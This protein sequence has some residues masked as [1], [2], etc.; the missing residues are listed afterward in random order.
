MKRPDQAGASK[1]LSELH[2][3]SG[4][5]GVQIDDAL[6]L[7][8]DENVVELL[9]ATHEAILAEGLIDLK[10][11]G[12][13]G[14]GVVLRATDSATGNPRAVKVMINADSPDRMVI[15]DRECRILDAAE[16]PP[17]VA[18][19]FY[20]AVKPQSAQ[21]FVVQ[22]WIS[23]QKLSDWLDARPKLPMSDRESLCRLIFATYSKLHQANLIHRD[24]SLGNIMVS[25]RTIRLIDF[26]GGGRAVAGYR[27]RNT[28]SQ[29][30][31]TDAFV[32]NAVRLRE[33]KPSI[34]DEVHA[35]AKVCFTVLTGQ[36]AL[37]KSPNDWKQILQL[38]RVAGDIAAIV[39][40][41]MQEPPQ[42][43]AMLSQAREF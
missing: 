34:A 10:R 30:P 32:S 43:L 16:M 41:K 22:E 26:G 7:V 40:S 13:G 15:F 11:I 42:D 8:D 3:D 18:P 14:Y 24:V 6:G 20:K 36:L 33:R 39:L 12:R 37:G 27:S 9:P 25:G 21:P 17:G 23:G 4:P 35:V 5:I 2:S 29:V 1:P 19:K 28:M 38:S 31:T